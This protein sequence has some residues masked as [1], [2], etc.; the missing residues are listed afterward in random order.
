MDTLLICNVYNGLGHHI[1]KNIIMDFIFFFNNTILPNIIIS[2]DEAYKKVKNFSDEARRSFLMDQPFNHPW[3]YLFESFPKYLHLISY[4]GRALPT[5]DQPVRKKDQELA[6][7]RYFNMDWT[8]NDANARKVGEQLAAWY[9]AGAKIIKKEELPYYS[10]SA[11]LFT[12]SKKGGQANF[13]R[14]FLTILN[15][16]PSIKFEGYPVFSTV[17]MNIS[18]N[19]QLINICHALDAPFLEHLDNCIGPDCPHQQLHFPFFIMGLEETGYRTRCASLPAPTILYMTERIRSK[20]LYGMQND[21]IAGPALK[22]ARDEKI[23]Q[24]FK[25]PVIN[26]VDFEQATDNFSLPLQYHFYGALRNLVPKMNEKYLKASFTTNRILESTPKEH[27]PEL[28]F[29]IKR[30]L[31]GIDKMPTVRDSIEKIGNP[32][33]RPYLYRLFEEEIQNPAGT[34]KKDVYY[35]AP[36]IGIRPNQQPSKSGIIPIQEHLRQ[37]YERKNIGQHSEKIFSDMVYYYRHLFSVGKGKMSG[38][39]QHMS[40]PLSWVA[41][42]AVNVTAIKE[43]TRNNQG[44]GFT[45]GDDAIIGFKEGPEQYRAF[46]ESLGVKIHKT[47]DILASGKGVFCE[48]YTIRRHGFMNIPK[49]KMISQP[50]IP[51]AESWI[52]INDKI[53]DYIEQNMA[54]EIM[55]IRVIK[56]YIPLRQSR[57]WGYDPSFPKD[58][59]GMELPWTSIYPDVQ[60][61]IEYIE[62]PEEFFYTSQRFKGTL[63]PMNDRDFHLLAL[64]S[65]GLKFTFSE[66]VEFEQFTVQQAMD[67]IQKELLRE[68]IYKKDIHAIQDTTPQMNEVG[69]YFSRAVQDYRDNRPALGQYRHLLAFI[70]INSE[71]LRNLREKY[72]LSEHF[73]IRINK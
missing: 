26:S 2:T 67:L 9:E 72:S 42:S 47:K 35:N 55:T 52:H 28:D 60:K 40:L 38:S 53:P 62:N 25:Y 41:L 16:G 30:H 18:I 43:S 12:G 69:Y 19:E 7:E 44:V 21:P 29:F 5:K 8:F 33:F 34:S 23:F 71:K 10:E 4:M 68:I 14:D 39:G 20:L 63:S 57:M 65:T 17:D 73:Y 24:I 11:C 54:D 56:N 36:V 1:H 32:S 48:D 22:K 58:F 31:Y 64:V 70:D 3:K 46:V 66:H 59:G 27:M 49:I 13:F 37:V 45:M 15:S 51:R 6:R 61:E 50:K